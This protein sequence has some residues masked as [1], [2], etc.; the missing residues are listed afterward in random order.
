MQ[1]V[2]IFILL[3][4]L[5]TLWGNPTLA[6]NQNQ[7]QTVSQ[8]QNNQN[9]QNQNQNQNNQNNQNQNPTKV[10]NGTTPVK[11]GNSTNGSQKREN[12]TITEGDLNGCT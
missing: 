12:G 3:V 2:F 8:N 1:K 10:I 6:Q 5:L 7:N 9:N 11:T 4:T